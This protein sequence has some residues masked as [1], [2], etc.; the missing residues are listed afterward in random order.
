MYI[1]WLKL[2]AQFWKQSNSNATLQLYVQKEGGFESIRVKTADVAGTLI[3]V[4]E[5]LD[6][7]MYADQIWWVGQAE[8]FKNKVIIEVSFWIMS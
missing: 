1:E 8:V 4:W 5:I 7:S 3:T 6:T 2:I